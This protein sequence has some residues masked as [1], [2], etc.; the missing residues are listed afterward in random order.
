MDLSIRDF[1]PGDEGAFLQLNEVWIRRYFAMEPKDEAT[2][3]DPQGKILDHGGRIFMAVLDDGAAV[4]CC[5][6]LEIANEGYEV[7]KM[8]VSD[9][10]KGKGIG[11]KLL[12]HAIQAAWASGAKHLYLETNHML[13]PAITLYQSVGFQHLPQKPSEYTRADVYMELLR[14]D[15]A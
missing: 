2:L 7:A 12:Q 15:S 11:R 8:A 4:G 5:A 14:P 1:Q 10:H 3:K 13:T 6:L 9:D